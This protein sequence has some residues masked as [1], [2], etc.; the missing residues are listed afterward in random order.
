M[1][2]KNIVSSALESLAV[3]FGVDG[4]YEAI[5][6]D[7]L[8]GAVKN[9]VENKINDV[10][11]GIKDIEKKAEEVKGYV[12]E[13]WNNLKNAVGDFFASDEEKA[14]KKAEEEAKKAKEEAEKKAAE[15]QAAAMR[16]ALDKSYILH[17]ALLVCDKA[18]TNEEIHP[19]YIVLPYSHGESIHGLPQLNV[20]DYIG[21]KNVLNFGICR[22]PKNPKVQ[23]AAR[24]ILDEVKEESKS[25]TDKLLGIFVDD[26]VDDVC[27][28][29][30]SLAA[31]CAGPCIPE[32]Y[33]KWIDG[34]EDVLIDG[35]PAL[36]GRCTLCCKYGGN[37]TIQSSGQLV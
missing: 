34:K 22:S 25:W 8:L 1:S 6:K 27:D 7:G 29:Q 12:K 37:I 9:G 20:D 3:E 32:F 13:D 4:A 15:E 30:E 19:S 17:T 31:Y 24:K 11:Q 10:K 14:A 28:S 18:Y 36:L 26:S 35:S 16:E 33:Q 21:D 23:E 5:Q 2:E